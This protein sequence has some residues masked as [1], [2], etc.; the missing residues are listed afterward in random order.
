M[1]AQ[2]F[3]FENVKEKEERHKLLQ[4]ALRDYSGIDSAEIVYKFK[5]RPFI[6]GTAKDM[7]VSV[8]TV[9]EVMVCVFSEKPIGIDG[10]NIVRLK[11]ENSTVDYLTL[12]ERFFTSE[13]ADYCRDGDPIN[14]ANVWMRKEAYCKYAGLGLKDFHTFSVASDDKLFSKVK[15]VPIKKFS[16]QFPGSSDYMFVIAGEAEF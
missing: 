4:S 13:E 16:P 15:G 9:G 3:V 10:E 5:D 8:T 11:D 2:V 7:F 14:F 12:A 1:A 6:K